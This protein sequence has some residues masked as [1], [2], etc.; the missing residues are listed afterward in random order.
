MLFARSDLGGGVTGHREPAF[1][2]GLGILALSRGGSHF[3]VAIQ[4]QGSLREPLLFSL[5]CHFIRGQVI[6]SPR[7]GFQLCQEN[8]GK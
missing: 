3:A 5:L 8:D 2:A 6:T 4:G 1:P 7:L